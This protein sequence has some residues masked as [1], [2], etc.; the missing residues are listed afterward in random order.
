MPL[1]NLTPGGSMPVRNSYAE[2]SM[3]VRTDN[4]LGTTEVG[5]VALRW[6]AKRPKLY[7]AFTKFVYQEAELRYLQSAT[8]LEERAK[9][10]A[11]LIAA[12]DFWTELDMCKIIG[13]YGAAVRGYLETGHTGLMSISS[14][15]DL[16]RRVGGDLQRLQ[17]LR[18]DMRRRELLQ[19]WHG[20][21]VLPRNCEEIWRE[22]F[23]PTGLGYLGS[24]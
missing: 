24:Y 19:L 3:L 8:E 5:E 12:Y 20:L 11:R 9:Y 16:A 14:D 6:Y 7:A 1:R 23:L 10:F 15:E 21:S 2:G 4:E 18:E 13:Q 17:E 22:W